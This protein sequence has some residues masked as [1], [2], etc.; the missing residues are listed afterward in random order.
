MTLYV[1]QTLEDG[2]TI[3]ADNTDGTE[4]VLKPGQWSVVA[5]L[6]GDQQ[7][8]RVEAFVQQN[9]TSGDPRT[10]ADQQAMQTAHD[11]Q[12]GEAHQSQVQDQGPQ[13]G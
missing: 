4:W 5:N 10:T 11:A 3:I 8:A 1:K 2:A 7:R 13:G 12:T 9:T 6:P